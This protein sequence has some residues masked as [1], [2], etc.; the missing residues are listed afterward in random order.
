MGGSEFVAGLPVERRGL[1]L[2][3]IGHEDAVLLRG[4]GAR[5]DVGALQRLRVVAEDVEDGEDALGGVLGAGDV[6]DRVLGIHALRRDEVSEWGE[7]ES[8]RGK[9]GSY[10]S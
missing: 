8:G 10:K 2:E 4:I 5:D 6:W 1:A 7:K 9:G 3:P